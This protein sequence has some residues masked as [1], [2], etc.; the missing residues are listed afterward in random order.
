MFVAA[1]RFR[2][3]PAHAAEFERAWLTRESH[4]HELPGFLEF[5]LLKGPQQD[6]HILYSSLTLWA[7]RD[8]FEAWTRSEQFRRA[9]AG[10]GSTKP[11]TLGPPQF[12]GFDV[13]QT[14]AAPAKG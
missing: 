14:I 8:A 10:A 1:N 7:S 3:I 9:H 6:D 5:H 12:E 13:L 4:L 2:V 11:I